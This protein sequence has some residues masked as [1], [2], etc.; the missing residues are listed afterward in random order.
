MV[1]KF[2]KHHKFLIFIF[3]LIIAF[4]IQVSP[5]EKAIASSTNKTALPVIMYHQVSK[6]HTKAGK[7]CV[8][9][10]QLREDLVYIKNKGYS[11]ITMSQ[12]INHVYHNE[13]IPEKPIIIT[14]DDGFESIMQYVYPLLKELNMCA[15]VSV[16]GSYADFTEEQD[17]HNV[18]YAYLDWKEISEL[19][20]SKNIEI[21]NHSYNMHIINSERRGVAKCAGEDLDTYKAV[22]SEDIMRFQNKIK[23][24]A[25]Y[26]PN[27]FTYPF[28]AF[29]MESPDVLKELG[30]KAA[31]V[32]EERIN[33]I[34]KEN[35]DWMYNIGRYNREH[36]SSTEN[37]FKKILI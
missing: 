29:S 36:S 35:T 16:V 37:F 19:T 6:K 28:G 8:L 30:F 23:Q 17:D 11:T 13:K 18:N 15:V 27:T 4:I 24:E 26:T 25:D 21:Q 20:K 31:L 22:F 12:L 14:F 2:D 33:Y 10:N 3:M 32:C 1:F 34:D 5:V 7:Y 9:L